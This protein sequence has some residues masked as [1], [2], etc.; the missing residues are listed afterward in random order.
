MRIYKG[1]HVDWATAADLWP[2]KAVAKTC[3]RDVSKRVEDVFVVCDLI[4]MGVELGL[5]YFA[6]KSG[7]SCETEKCFVSEFAHLYRCLRPFS[8]RC[9]FMR[10]RTHPSWR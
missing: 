9:D 7:S 2:S 8:F 1:P 6:R 5:C 4:C 10:I 3:E